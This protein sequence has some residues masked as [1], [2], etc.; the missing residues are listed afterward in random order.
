MLKALDKNCKEVLSQ[1]MKSNVF[2]FLSAH[3]H[4]K[5]TTHLPAPRRS[6]LCSVGQYPQPCISSVLECRSLPFF[7]R[8]KPFKWLCL[9]WGTADSPYLVLLATIKSIVFSSTYEE[10]P[11]MNL[12]LHGCTA[13]WLTDSPPSL[14]AGPF[15]A[16]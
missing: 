6:V 8:A 9:G 7:L 3:A 13:F 4:K 2:L 1:C 5:A 12:S 16:W 14:Q 11:E 10:R 15:Q